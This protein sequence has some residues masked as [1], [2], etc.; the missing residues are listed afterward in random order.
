MTVRGEYSD[1]FYHSSDLN[2]YKFFAVCLLLL[3]SVSFSFGSEEKPQR[4]P[5]VAVLWFEN[6]TGDSQQAHWRYAIEGIL[7]NLCRDIGS[8]RLRQGVDYGRREL[9]IDKG[10]PIDSVA[11]RKIGEIIEAQ[12][13]IWGSY[14]HQGGRWHVSVQV[15]NVASGEFCDPLEVDSTDFFEMRD[16]LVEHVLKELKITPSEKEREKL[17]ERFTN[18][19]KA[20]DLYTQAYALQEEN[21]PLADQEALCRKSIDADPNFAKAHGALATVLAS[22]GKFE[23]AEK[24]I[25]RALEIKPD[26]EQGQLALGFILFSQGKI[27][28]A[29]RVISK[30]RRLWPDEPS[31]LHMLAGLYT[32]WNKWDQVIAYSEQAIILDPT[33]AEYHALLGGAYAKKGRREQAIA[34]LKEAQRLLDTESMSGINTELS[35]YQAYELLAEIP[36]ALEHYEKFVGM[37]KK[38]GSNPEMVGKIE[39]KK[40]QLKSSLT[41]SVVETSMPKIY[42]IES[43]EDILKEKLTEEEL[44]LVFNPLD[45][46]PEIK[47]W[48][49]QLTAGATSD[50]EKAKALFDE[51]I[52]RPWSM[53]GTRTAQE[54]F[55]AWQ[56][57]GQSFNCQEYAKLFVAMA[58]EVKI[59]AFY[60]HVWKDHTGKII[61]HACALFFWKVKRFWSIPLI[62]GLVYLTR[63]LLF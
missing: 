8:I 53:G 38:I 45:S 32:Q 34:A 44:N 62:A 4:K 23:K 51:M 29:E 63:L 40:E 1:Q 25:R 19:L 16:M 15:L 6:T 39:K 60:T 57:P 14:K 17:S 54:V 22:Q 10:T 2:S 9:G 52:Q 33:N 21:K 27:V 48:A 42:T 61:Y 26:H 43:L 59:K 56:K 5:T 47:R 50:I 49:E 35:I 41:P 37:A 28:Q 24:V 20:M 12:R 36:L 7:T 30:V 46:S 58:R 18:S 31:P 3:F 11:A 55:A 13:V